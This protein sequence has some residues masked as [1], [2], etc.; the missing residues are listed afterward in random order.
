MDHSE[1][2]AS[3]ESFSADLKE[4]SGTVLDVRQSVH[5]FLWQRHPVHSS[6]MFLIPLCMSIVISYVEF[7]YLNVNA[8]DSNNMQIAMFFAGLPLAIPLV[9]YVRVYS[10]MKKLFYTELA[11]ALGCVYSTNG[12]V[13]TSGQLFTFGNDHR[14]TNVLSGT[15]KDMSLRLADYSYTKQSGKNRQTYVCTF[16]ELTTNGALPKVLCIPA[17]WWDNVLIESWKPSGARQ[18]SLEGD[19]NSKFTVYVPQD[20]EMEA[21]QILEP[22]VMAKLMDGFANYGFECT[23]SHMYLFTTG[24]MKENRESILALS[25]LLKRFCDLLLPELQSFLRDTSTGPA[26]V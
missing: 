25:S 16:G 6:L 21:L 18:L 23:D 26:A 15:Y 5:N 1:N 8:T 20:Q 11:T 10:R 7:A 4:Y 22:D 17:S 3:P 9:F 19:F 2:P 14:V 13:P 12:E 24:T